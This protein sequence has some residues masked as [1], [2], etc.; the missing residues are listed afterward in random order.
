M[1]GRFGTWHALLGWFVAGAG[2]ATFLVVTQTMAVGGLAGLLSVG[3]SSELRPLIEAELGPIPLSPGSGHDGQISY[4]V[5]LDLTGREVP[6]TL[7]H[8]GYRYRRILYPAVASLFGS[9]SGPQ[10]LWSM[11]VVNVTALGIATTAVISIARSLGRSPWTVLGV[12]A[13]PGIWLSVRLLTVD[14]L[15][16][17]LAL[18]GIALW[19]NRRF[20]TTVVM[21]A[22]AALTKD[23]YLIVGFSIAAFEFWNRRPQRGAI[24]ALVPPLTLAAW[25]SLIGSRMAGTFSPRGNLDLP[26]AG[27]IE[28]FGQWRNGPVV[29]AALSWFL[30]LAL[31]A[32]AVLLT[33]PR[34][35]SHLFFVAPWILL[36]SVSSEWV[37]AFG[38][39]AVRA[40]APVIVWIAVGLA[41]DRSLNT[42]IENLRVAHVD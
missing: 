40:F 30:I 14:V 5:G 42:Q 18:C 25:S 13:N 29:D 19:L 34:N 9:L 28:A 4:V 8:P 20:T 6:S 23:Q 27:I 38:N 35:R 36:A 12:L 33:I 11:V 41:R 15:A 26:L 22:L 32:A 17:A 3:E 24:A 1:T 39:N 16:I 10:L 2:V 31:V 7:D 21:L 37:W